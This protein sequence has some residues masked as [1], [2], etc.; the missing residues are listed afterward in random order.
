[1]GARIGTSMGG[2]EE[3]DGA[4]LLGLRGDGQETRE[5]GEGQAC[6]DLDRGAGQENE[7]LRV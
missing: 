2:I 7:L 1:M 4:G 6:C 3:D 5:E